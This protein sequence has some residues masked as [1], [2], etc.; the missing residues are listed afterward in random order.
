MNVEKI[1]SSNIA[2]IQKPKKEIGL[3]WIEEAENGKD[4]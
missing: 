4:N 2:Y 3:I 1:E